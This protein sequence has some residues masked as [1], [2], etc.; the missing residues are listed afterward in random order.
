[1]KL[2]ERYCA[3]LAAVAR[4]RLRDLG[5]RRRAED[6]IDAVQDAFTA[7]FRR[8]ESGAYPDCRD[9]NDLCCLL[10]KIIDNKARQLA[11][12][13]RRGKRGAGKVRGDSVFFAPGAARGG[14]F[15]QLAA[16][17]GELAGP[18][19]EEPTEAFVDQ[20]LDTL[21]DCYGSL[22]E[23]ERKVLRGQLQGYTHAEI[24]E[25]IGC[26]TRTVERKLK[27]IRN[28]WGASVAE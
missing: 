18:G 12:G 22:D 5:A 15:D 1:Q 6:E 24:A 16:A 26:V 19:V 27:V 10:V 20:L 14:G 8:V 2:W 9:R 7:F 3:Q 28:R 25:Q 4:R 11:R 17:T 13:E 21:V 23:L